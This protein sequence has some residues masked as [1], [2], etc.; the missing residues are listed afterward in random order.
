MEQTRKQ[1]EVC[2]NVVKVNRWGNSFGIRIPKEF[3]TLYDIDECSQF[4][5]VDKMGTISLIPLKKKR[6]HITLAERLKDW[7][8][9]PFETELVDLGNVVGEEVDW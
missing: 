4:K 3:L 6:E 5:F 1:S 8:G 2:K 7:D 9:I